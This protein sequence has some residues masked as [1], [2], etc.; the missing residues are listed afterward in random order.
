MRC[1]WHPATTCFCIFVVT[2]YFYFIGFSILLLIR[3]C[4]LII[5]TGIADFRM[6]KCIH[7]SCLVGSY[8]L[9]SNKNCPKD[10]LF[11][12]YYVIK[13]RRTALSFILH[14]NVFAQML[15]ISFFLYFIIVRKSIRTVM[16]ENDEINDNKEISFGSRL[17]IMFL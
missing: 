4:F 17:V 1:C 6:V 7:L 11:C 9:K 2:L 5:V 3:K 14:F 15:F 10:C 12:F 13:S 8:A 16:K